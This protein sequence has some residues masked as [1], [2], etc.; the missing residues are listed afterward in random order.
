[1]GASRKQYRAIV[2]SRRTGS[3]NLSSY[4]NCHCTNSG[5][6]V[7]IDQYLGLVGIA[8]YVLPV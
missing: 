5:T 3:V 4:T 6:I 7:C 1:M 8:Q 2:Q